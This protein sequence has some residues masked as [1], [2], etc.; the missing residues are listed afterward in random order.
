MYLLTSGRGGN[1]VHSYRQN[2]NTVV[3]RPSKLF[4]SSGVKNT[5]IG[6][7]NNGKQWCEA[8]NLDSHSNSTTA[9][10]TSIPFDSPLNFTFKNIDCEKYCDILSF[11]IYI[12]GWI[13]SASLYAHTRW[14]CLCLKVKRRPRS[15]ARAWAKLFQLNFLSVSF[16]HGFKSCQRGHPTL[17]G[18]SV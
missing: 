10:S 17:P 9:A 1:A 11:S 18:W 13:V 16:M 3:K 2:Q 7:R 14:S 15:L 8:M 4:G 6:A 12:R 5:P